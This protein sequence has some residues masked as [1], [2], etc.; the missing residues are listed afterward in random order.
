MSVAPASP[1]PY[2]HTYRPLYEHSK[3]ALDHDHSWNDLPPHVSQAEQKYF[4][5][6]KQQF[7]HCLFMMLANLATVVE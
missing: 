3:G 1:C 6:R 5:W 2:Q 7:I 4:C